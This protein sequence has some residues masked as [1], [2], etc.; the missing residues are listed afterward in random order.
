MPCTA[1]SPIG[2]RDSPRAAC[3]RRGSP[4]GWRPTTSVKVPPRSI[5]KSQGAVVLRAVHPH[6]RSFSIAGPS[7][8]GDGAET[9]RSRPLDAELPSPQSESQR[10]RCVLEF[11][12]VGRRCM[13]AWSQGVPRLQRRVQGSPHRGAECEEIID[14]IA[15]H[16]ATKDA[17]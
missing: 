14:A 11:R 8:R 12:K 6:R 10:P 5:Q 7:Y 9:K 3:A 16:S 4:S 17:T 2:L 15:R 1:A 13:K